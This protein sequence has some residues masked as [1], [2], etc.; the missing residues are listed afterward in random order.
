MEKCKSVLSVFLAVLMAA[1]LGFSAF[2]APDD[3]LFSGTAGDQVT[4]TL[5]KDGVLRVSGS[6]PI[7]DDSKEEPDENGHMVTTTYDSIGMTLSREYAAAVEGMKAADAARVCFDLVKEIV[8]EEGITAIPSDE[9]TGM[10]PC[11]VTLPASLETLGF[12]TFD[13]MFAEEIVINSVKLREAD[14]H[15][16]AYTGSEAPFADVAAAREGYIEYRETQ[17]AYDYSLLPVNVL[18]TFADVYFHGEEAYWSGLSE[19]DRQE[20]YDLYNGYFGTSASALEDFVPVALRMLNEKYGTS[21]TD[22]TEIYSL[23]PEEDGYSEIITDPPL[24]EKFDEE[25]NALSDQWLLT[26]KPLGADDKFRTVCSWF[27]VTA[28]AGGSIEANCRAS[29]VNFHA[30]EG[31]T[32]PPEEDPDAC[33]LCGKDHSGNL[34]QKFVGFLHRI[35]YFFLHL[36]DNLKIGK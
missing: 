6:G 1:S 9:F 17:E 8:V 33:K 36:F 29:G 15:I 7:V 5:T 31:V 22:I 2:A 18:Y 30:L 34:W 32:V 10:Y 25:A 24:Q 12:N 19:E 16:P 20:A 21:Y 13:L 35:V 27:T 23:A 3:V 28:P 26:V 4:W 14:L 11:R